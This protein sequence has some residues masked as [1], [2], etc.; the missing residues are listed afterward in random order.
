MYS[1]SYLTPLSILIFSLLITST[2]S[3]T[4]IQN[5]FDSGEESEQEYEIT[6]FQKLTLA[7]L[8]EKLSSSRTSH[9]TSSPIWEW[10]V[11][12]GG[13]RPLDFG[14]LGIAVDSSGNA[15]VSGS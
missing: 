2:L 4:V 10:A 15:Y 11:K 7:D 6:D 3:S 1:S 5:Q 12:A 9:T 8:N 13:V 14:G